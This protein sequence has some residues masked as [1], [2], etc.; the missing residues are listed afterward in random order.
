[1]RWELIRGPS[2]LLA[3]IATGLQAG[4]YYSFSCAVM[5]GLQLGDAR[6]F[7]AAM[8]Q[9][10]IAIINPW[11]MVTFLGAPLLAAI[12]GALQVSRGGTA[13]ALTA[14]GFVFTLAT[15]VITVA[16]N[17]PLNDA[18]A[19][20]GDPT[21]IVDPA[22]VRDRFEASWVRWNTVRALTSTLSLGCLGWALV[23]SRA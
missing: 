9:I 5:P 14:A 4:V 13:L 21:Q 6:T 12:A 8:Q 22:S 16:I 15:F 20:A 10:N 19:A 3:A 23:V 11:F 1:V 17:V 2:L 18:L 7:I